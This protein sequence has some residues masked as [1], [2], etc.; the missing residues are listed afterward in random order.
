MKLRLSI[1][2]LQSEAQK[3][4]VDVVFAAV[5]ARPSSAVVSVAVV[6]RMRGVV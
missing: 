2:G 4:I 3:R 6:Q 1:K 5:E